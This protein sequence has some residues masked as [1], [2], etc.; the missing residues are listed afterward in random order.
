MNQ[1]ILRL[2]I[3][4]HLTSGRLPQDRLEN[5]WGGSGTGETCDGCGETVTKGQKLMD[6]LD[7]TEREVHFHVACFLV[8]EVERQSMSGATRSEA[9]IPSRAN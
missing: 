3:R 5:M 9:A 8:W 1:P 4:E 2:V 7:L 6:V